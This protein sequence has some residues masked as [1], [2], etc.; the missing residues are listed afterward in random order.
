MIQQYSALSVEPVS[1]Q[2]LSSRLQK[3]F[4]RLKFKRNL[5]PTRNRSRNLVLDFENILYLAFVPFGPEMVPILHIDEL[6]RNAE[7]SASPAHV[8]LLPD[9]ADVD[10]LAFEGKSR[11]ACNDMK[12]RDLH[13][14]ETLVNSTGLL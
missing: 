13:N 6:C 12:L 9:G 2:I 3:R 5:Q 8:Q 14:L 10:V 11:G 4:L 1:F 7:P